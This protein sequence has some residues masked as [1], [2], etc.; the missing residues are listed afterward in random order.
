MLDYE[1]EKNLY[2]SPFGGGNICIFFKS[3]VEFFESIMENSIDNMYYNY[4]SHI[5]DTSEEW[6]ETYFYMVIHIK[7]KYKK[8]IMNYYNNNCGSGSIT[9]RESIKRILREEYSPAGK[10]IIPNRIVVHK[11][12]PIFRNNIMSEGL[13]AKAGE[14]YK[15]YA[16]YGEKCIPAIFATNSTNKRASFDS[17]YDD[18]VWEIDTEMIPDV[19]WYKDRHYES[20][21]KHI[22]TFENIPVDAITLKHEGTGNDWGLMESVD[23]SKEKKLKLVTKMIHEFFDEVSFIEITKYENKPMIKVYFDKNGK[24]S[25][26]EEESYFAE[27][28]K[29]KIYEYT[30]IK[31]IPYWHIIQ[32]NTDVDFRLDTIKL[33]YDGEGNVINESKKK[34]DNNIFHLENILKPFKNIY[35]ICGID[36]TY[37]D[38]CIDEN[39]NDDNYFIN[40]VFSME[41]IKE[42]DTIKKMHFVK[43]IKSEIRKEIESFF[44]IKNYIIGSS[45]KT[46]CP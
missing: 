27:Q 15:I 11:S 35:E 2:V 28:I 39:C 45:F 16:G 4:F 20:T 43:K 5:D 25:D 26:Y 29:D 22:V 38:I 32:Y 1:I 40:I 23:K 36:V 18:D 30:G 17:T 31:L 3:D 34:L 13:K 9:L 19:K 41:K 44:P 6:I 21:K 12:N 7:D 42:F 37:E 10:E 33:E 8:K 14:C 24:L 46:K